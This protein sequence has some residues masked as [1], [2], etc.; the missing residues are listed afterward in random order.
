MLLTHPS[1]MM[2][3]SWPSLHP[4]WKGIQILLTG[5]P[6]TLLSLLAG[7]SWKILL[8]HSVAISNHTQVT[9]ILGNNRIAPSKH[10]SGDLIDHCSETLVIIFYFYISMQLSESASVYWETAKT[11]MRGKIVTYSSHKWKQ[12]SRI[13]IIKEKKNSRRCL[14]LLPH[15]NASWQI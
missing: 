12:N 7:H 3:L 11:L 13:K 4:A 2:I 9:I 14:M 5:P 10:Q 15:K 1:V 8:T 6:F